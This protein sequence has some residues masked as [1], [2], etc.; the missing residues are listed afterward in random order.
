MCA[1]NFNTQGQSDMETGGLLNLVCHQP[2]FK[3]NEKPC[4]QDSEK[5][6]VGV[7]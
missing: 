3:F 1:C 7:L 4:L 6:A 2:S 5:R